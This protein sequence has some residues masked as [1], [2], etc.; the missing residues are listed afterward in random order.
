MKENN[1]N[2]DSIN[3]NDPGWKTAWAIYSKE[4]LSKSVFFPWGLS[5][6]TILI[7]LFTTNSPITLLLYSTELIITI[8]PCILGFTLAGYALIMGLSNSE[9]MKGLKAFK[10]EGKEYTLFQS[11]NATFAIVLGMLFI[12]TLTGVVVGIII[13]AE[14]PMPFCEKFTDVCNWLCLFTL[15][16]LLYYTINSIKDIVINIFNLGQFAQIYTNAEDED[17]DD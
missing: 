5:L 10:Q 13:K 3:I 7:C 17:N 8:V 4:N 2:N 11:L 14:I 16:F 9:F 1:R 6:V 15:I 12:T